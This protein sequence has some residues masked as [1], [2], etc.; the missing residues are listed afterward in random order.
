MSYL[1]WRDDMM[2]RQLQDGGYKIIHVC[3]G[4]IEALFIDDGGLLAL[5]ERGV[6]RVNIPQEWA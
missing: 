2:C 5:T 1:T 3:Q 6:E 4:T